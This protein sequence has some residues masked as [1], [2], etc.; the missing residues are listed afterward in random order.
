MNLSFDC[1]NQKEEFEK[2]YLYFNPEKEFSI[3]PRE[4]R[5]IEI[6]YNPKARVHNFKKE[7]WFKIIDN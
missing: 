1:E 4:K 5:D 6:R 3:G 7:F 2:Y